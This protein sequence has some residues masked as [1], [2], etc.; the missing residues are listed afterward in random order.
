MANDQQ[1]LSTNLS[2]IPPARAR[3]PRPEEH[4]RGGRVA[5]SLLHCEA[6]ICIYLWA[7]A[8]M[9]EFQPIGRLRLRCREERAGLLVCRRGGPTCSM[10]SDFEYSDDDFQEQDG[11]FNTEDEAKE[12]TMGTEHSTWEVL[13]VDEL[14]HVQARLSPSPKVPFLSPFSHN[15]L[16]NVWGAQG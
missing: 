6:A 9:H 2:R 10:D 1:N 15:I 16:A 7:S 8:R 11:G 3:L 5:F 14:A 4:L 13:A 12:Q